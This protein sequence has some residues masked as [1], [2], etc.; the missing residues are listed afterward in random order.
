VIATLIAIAAGGAVGSVARFL[1]TTG[2]SHLFGVKYPLGTLLV[3]V[4]GSFAVGFVACFMLRKFPAQ[5]PLRY[6]LTTGFLGGFTTFS[7]FSLD[8]LTMLQRGDTQGTVFYV[9]AS[10]GL[11]LIAVLAGYAWAQ[12]VTT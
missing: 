2:T 11:S 6:F 8:V 9:I 10:V 12:A 4:V 3:N 7:A 5:E 1:V